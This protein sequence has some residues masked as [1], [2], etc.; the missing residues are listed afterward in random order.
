MPFRRVVMVPLMAL[1]LSGAGLASVPMAA[2][3]DA[4]SSGKPASVAELPPPSPKTKSG[5]CEL[6]EQG[7]ADAAF[8]LARRY[9]FGKGVRKDRRLGTAWL[10]AAASRGH[11]EA[12]QLVNYVPG[13]MGRIR[14]WCRPGAGPVREV[15][16]PPAEVVSL[17]NSI[18]PKYGVDP[19]LVLAVVQAE[20]AFRTDAV[21]PKDAA[22]LMQL[23]PDTA[24][25]FGVGNVFDPKENITGGVKYL[26]W[27][28]AYFQ[29]DVT[30]ALAGYNAGEGAVDRYKGVPP[31]EETRNYVRIIRRNYDAVRHPFDNSV[32]A[33]SSALPAIRDAAVRDVEAEL[34]RSVKSPKKG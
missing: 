13:R 29:G 10:R 6:A 16:P 12:R 3:A 31:Y 30:L 11:P 33:P 25:R 26:R 4:K 22:G 20:S 1:A 17:V 2:A 18:A 21:S 5:D 27:L 28:L 7:D 15:G 23:I 34:P 32:A 9:L 14:P 24:D 8:R 19:A